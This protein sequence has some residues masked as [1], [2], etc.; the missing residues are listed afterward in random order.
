MR[1]CLNALRV[2]L[3]RNASGGDGDSG[4]AYRYFDPK[5]YLRAAN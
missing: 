1:I 2:Q 3:A 5:R 4:I